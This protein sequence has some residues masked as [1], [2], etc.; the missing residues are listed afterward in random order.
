MFISTEAQF[1]VATRLGRKS[2]ICRILRRQR[3]LA[4]NL[5]L[6]IRLTNSRSVQY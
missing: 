2:A 5:K 6:W 4:G 1:E 3:L